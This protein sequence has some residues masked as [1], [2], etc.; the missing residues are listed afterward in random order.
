LTVRSTEWVD[1]DRNIPDSLFGGVGVPFT[2]IRFANK[3]TGDRRKTKRHKRAAKY[4][5]AHLAKQMRTWTCRALGGNV[6]VGSTYLIAASDGL[7][8]F[9]DGMLRSELNVRDGMLIGF[10]PYFKHN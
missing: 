4:T 5:S 9:G 6:D 3:L 7:H 10:F 1:D 8:P 2:T